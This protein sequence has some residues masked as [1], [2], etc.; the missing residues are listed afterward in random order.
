MRPQSQPQKRSVTKDGPTPAEVKWRTILQRVVK[1]GP[2][3]G[4][5]WLDAYR[6]RTQFGDEPETLSI[7]C[8]A[9]L[10]KISRTSSGFW[11]TRR[12]S[13]RKTFIPAAET[14]ASLISS[15]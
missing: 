3:G 11:K 9:N 7:Y 6:T 12:A 13:N 8:Y 1:A 10:R 15:A 5:G 4:C 2:S 14:S